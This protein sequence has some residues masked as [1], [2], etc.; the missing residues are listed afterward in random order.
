MSDLMKY[1]GY[2]GSCNVSFEDGVLHG[3]VE[4]INDLVTYEATTPAEIQAAFEEAVDDYLETCEVIGKEPDKVMSGSFNIRVGSDLHK[5]LYIESKKLGISL[6]DF[7]K[8]SLAQSLDEKK[9]VH[10]HLHV[11]ERK[12]EKEYTSEFSSKNVSNE[13]VLNFGRRTH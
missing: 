5:K 11:P 3:K 2:W 13:N 6:N 12:F 4:C 8:K 7:I 1:K 10:M 9:E